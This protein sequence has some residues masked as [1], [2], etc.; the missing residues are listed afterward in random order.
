MTTDLSKGFKWV[1][2]TRNYE[3]EKQKPSLVSI[4]P[5][6]HPLK[7]VIEQPKE[8]S[9]TS[10]AT[11]FDPLSP[12]SLDPLSKMVAE[13]SMKEKVTVLLLL[14]IFIFQ[15]FILARKNERKRS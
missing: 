1:A 8:L 13:V 3:T 2:K 12:T 14:L 4:G 5:N 10:S 9:K 11:F 7:S 6:D 15:L